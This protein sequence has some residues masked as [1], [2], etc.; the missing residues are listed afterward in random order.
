MKGWVEVE[1]D[2]SQRMRILGVGPL[3]D[4]EVVRTIRE[5]KKCSLEQNRK[6]RLERIATA[7]LGAFISYPE[8]GAH[9]IADHA[10]DIAKV[11]VAKIDQEGVEQR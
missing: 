9:Q 2:G 10:L 8:A 3:S 11:L 7:C 6:D 4:D 1:H 5:R